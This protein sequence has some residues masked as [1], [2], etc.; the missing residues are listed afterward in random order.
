MLNLRT[1]SLLLLVLTAGCVT[2]AV[3][4]PTPP[5]ASRAA[6][7][8]RAVEWRER[9]P[10]AALLPAGIRHAQIVVT[11]GRDANERFAW[12]ISEGTDV[13]QVFRVD[14]RELGD[15]TAAIGDTVFTPIGSP[16][17]S[18][19]WVIVGSIHAPGPN[20]PGPPGFPDDYIQKIMDHAWNINRE[21]IAHEGAIGRR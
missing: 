17:D 16:G 11:R 15:F 13:L 20:P 21:Q 14:F 7:E 8:A 19:S 5:R 2:A 3:A 9:D 4:S 18:L 10:R 6:L 1:A 12:L